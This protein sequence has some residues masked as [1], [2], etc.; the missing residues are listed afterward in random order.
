MSPETKEFLTGLAVVG[1]FAIVMGAA[2]AAYVWA[3]LAVA[4]M[5]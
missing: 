5:R 3:M 4:G 1:T 2:A